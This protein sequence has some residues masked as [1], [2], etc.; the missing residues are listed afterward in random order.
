MYRF[1][2]SLFNDLCSTPLEGNLPSEIFLQLPEWCVYIQTPGLSWADRSV[3]GVFISLE[4]DPNDFR[5]ELRFVFVC[6][7]LVCFPFAIHLGPWDLDESIRRMVAESERNVDIFSGTRE[8]V[9]DL[10]NSIEQIKTA[11]VPVINLVLYICSANADFNG[12]RPQHPA[13]RQPKKKKDTAADEVRVWDVG[14]RV[15]AAMR[16]YAEAQKTNREAGVSEGRTHSSP[17]PH[18][19][20]AHWHHFWTGPKAEPEKRQLILKWLP[21][22]PVNI[23]DIDTLPIT[24]IPLKPKQ[25]K[26][27]E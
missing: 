4:Y 13:A 18:V 8:A 19:R 26:D 24:L 7:D 27:K 23:D 5:Q 12:P 9:D 20:R 21:P 1:D 6:P 3:D 22:I 14:I 11:L 10:Y 16:K 25:E 15:G 17:R 2:E